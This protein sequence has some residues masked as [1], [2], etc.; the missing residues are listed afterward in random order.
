MIMRSMPCRLEVWGDLITVYYLGGWLNV[1]TQLG[2]DISTTV[3]GTGSWSHAG[4]EL[5]GTRR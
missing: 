3:S 5:V 4:L 1:D 2:M